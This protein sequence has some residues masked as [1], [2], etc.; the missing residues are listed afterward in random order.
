M[1]TKCY[2]MMHFRLLK[3]LNTYL[4]DNENIKSWLAE[5]L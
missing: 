3:M 2:V 4:L 1:F 5:I